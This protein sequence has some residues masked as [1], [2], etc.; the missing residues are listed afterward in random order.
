MVDSQPFFLYI[1]DDP[2]SR[3]VLDMILTRIMKYSNT[4]YFDN[5][6]DYQEKFTGLAKVPDVIFLDIQIRPHNVY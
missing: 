4:E 3:E 5:S 2:L 1:E 6:E